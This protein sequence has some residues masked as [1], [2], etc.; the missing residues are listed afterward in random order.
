ME[1]KIR[2]EEPQDYRVV[3]EIAREAFWNLYFPGCHEH[4][5]IHK[6]R[7]HE[8][9]IQELSFVIEVEGRVVGGIFYT[10]SKIVSEDNKE[11][12]TISFGPVFISPEFHRKGLGR[13]LITHSI[14]VAK[15]MGYRAI[16]ALGYPYH[17]EP[18]GFLGGKTYNI[19]MPDKKFYKGLLVLP[20]YEGALNDISGYVIFSDVLEVDDD[21]VNEFDRSFPPKEKKFQESQ[22]EFEKAA[23][24]LDE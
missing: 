1:I 2:N 8:D 24:M 13:K 7:E 6:M 9:F 21:E 20:L 15:E 17:Y 18:Y 5:V 4:Y 10:N 12:K 14:E 11:Y 3:E 19:S 22:I 23:S 16:L